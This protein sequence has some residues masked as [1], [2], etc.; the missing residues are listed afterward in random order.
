MT[1][2][3]SGEDAGDYGAQTMPRSRSERESGYDAAAASTRSQR[4][5]RTSGRESDF[6]AA[7]ERA[8]TSRNASARDAVR[9]VTGRTSRHR[10]QSDAQRPTALSEEEEDDEPLAERSRRTAARKSASRAMQDVEHAQP[11]YA[12]Q[13]RSRGQDAGARSYPSAA[14]T[15]Y[16]PPAPVM[17]S[18]PRGDTGHQSDRFDAY[19]GADGRRNAHPHG[20]GYDQGRGRGADHRENDDEDE[21]DGEGWGL[22]GPIENRCCRVICAVSAAKD[23]GE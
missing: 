12:T 16:Y 4:S 22:P 21:D 20:Y 23:L 10:S 9:G 11:E 18:M 5:K 1:R 6:D 2:S 19:S 7:A 8:R 17:S 3:R 14:P 15:S 13:Y